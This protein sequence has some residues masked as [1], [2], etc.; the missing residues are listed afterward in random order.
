MKTIQKD[1][2]T[3]KIYDT[4]AEMGQGAAADIHDCIVKLL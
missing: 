4:R 1:N 3:V 2:L